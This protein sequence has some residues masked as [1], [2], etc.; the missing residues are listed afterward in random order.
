M[1][2][3]DEDAGRPEAVGDA[4]VDGV[5]ERKKLRVV[6]NNRVGN[7]LFEENW[8]ESEDKVPKR[9]VLVHIFIQV[10]H[11]F[12][13]PWNESCGDIFPYKLRSSLDV[14]FSHSQ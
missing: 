6:E 7:R 1:P 10:H 11:C 5:E 12:L 2:L 14:R 9:A 3:L 8:R 13:H 4:G